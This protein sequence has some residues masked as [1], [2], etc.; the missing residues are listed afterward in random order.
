MLKK[1][2]H[3]LPSYIQNYL[4]EAAAKVSN[5]SIEEFVYSDIEKTILALKIN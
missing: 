2:Y 1:I 4:N 3:N 5:N